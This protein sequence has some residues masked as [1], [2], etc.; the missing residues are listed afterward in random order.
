MTRWDILWDKQVDEDN[1]VDILLQNRGIK[2][3]SAR[4]QFLNPPP[5]LMAMKSLP[6]EFKDSAKL[7]RE[8]VFESIDRELPVVIHGDYDADGVCAA[9]ILH[10]VIRDELSYEKCF[11]FIPNRFEH[12]YGLSK[13]SIDFVVDSVSDK[14]GEFENALLITVDSGITAVDEVS[15]A[16]SLGFEVIISDHHQKPKK[17][18]TAE[19]ILWTDELVGSGISWALGKVLG[20]KDKKSISLAAIATV[21]DLQPLFGIN[22]SIVKYGLEVLNKAPPAGIKALLEFSGRRGGIVTTYDLGWVIGPRLN[23]SGRIEDATDSLALLL[24]EDPVMVEKYAARLNDTNLQRQ[25]KTQE[26]Y[27]LAGE[28]LSEKLPPLIISMNE[29]YHEGIIGL[30]ASKLVQQY[31]RPSIVISVSDE[32]GKGSVR[33]VPGF[34]IIDFL[35]GFED[36]FENLGG[37]P[38]AAGF[39]I[40]KEKIEVMRQKLLEAA[41]DAIDKD[42]LVPVITV[43]M[44]IPLN[45]VGSSLVAEIER[46]KPFGVGNKEPIFTSMGVGVGSINT[47]GRDNSHISMQLMFEGMG[48]KAIFFN[49]SE[50]LEELGV[51]VGDRVDVVYSVR[52]NNYRGKVYVDVVVKDLRL[53]V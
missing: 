18:P 44:K 16:K 25:D 45:L 10:K 32:F 27:E 4:E 33:S 52:E 35:R 8:K 14:F 50:K 21:T 37:H 28:I 3:K 41:A 9:A 34:D 1:I 29:D 6:D 20:S 2:G 40:R 31:Y 36:M 47:V 30:V 23:A 11:S 7:A 13:N 43:D 51:G 53:S 15:Y 39:T 48:Y 5:V 19:I 22:R 42:L 12:G 38:M 24:E 17:L 46:L 49:G 26:M